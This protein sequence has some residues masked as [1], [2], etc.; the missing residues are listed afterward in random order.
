[1]PHRIFLPR[2]KKRSKFL[3]IKSLLFINL[4]LL[5]LVFLRLYSVNVKDLNILGF[6]TD[7]RI[8]E[9]LDDTNNERQKL[10]LPALKYNDALSKAAYKKANNMFSEDY[11]AHISPSGKTP[12]DF[13]LGENYRYTYAG[14]NLAKDFQKSK[15]V[16]SAWMNSPTHKENIVNANY[17]EVGFAVVNGKLQGKETTLVVQMFGTPYIPAADASQNNVSEPEEPIVDVKGEK[18]EV[19]KDINPVETLKN[20]ETRSKDLIKIDIS[21][22]KYFSYFLLFVFLIALLIDGILAYKKHYLRLTGNTISHLILLIAVV[23]FI[24]IIRNPAIL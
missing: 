22:V 19:V 10:G 21:Y 2:K 5:G 14:E 11:W 24:Y 1:M 3:S 18:T 8:S 7:I 6:A 16:V 15:S 23:V 9:L 17:K 4:I 13:I 12:W 20:T